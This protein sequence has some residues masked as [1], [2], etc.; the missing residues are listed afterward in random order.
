[1]DRE[2]WCAVIHGVAKSRTR[3]SDW[4]ELRSIAISSKCL[5]LDLSLL[6]VR[7]HCQKIS[8]W[9]LHWFLKSWRILFHILACYSRPHERVSK[10]ISSCFP[11]LLSRHSIHHLNSEFRKPSELLSVSSVGLM[12]LSSTLCPHLYLHF[13]YYHLLKFFSDFKFQ[14]KFYVFHRVEILSP[15]PSCI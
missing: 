11:V 4:T 6:P 2:A 1:M 14:L 15:S 13:L 9:N 8:S 10:K 7:H 3:L 12:F 5:G